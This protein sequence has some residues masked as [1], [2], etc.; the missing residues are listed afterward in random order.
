MRGALQK[1]LMSPPLTAL[2]SLTRSKVGL[3]S[4]KRRG[5]RSDGL[6]AKPTDTL[7]F[8][9]LFR[10]AWILMNSPKQVHL[11]EWLKRS[12]LFQLKMS[13]SQTSF[14]RLKKDEFR[15][16]RLLKLRATFPSG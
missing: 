14:E 9:L 8:R 15:A 1:V 13:V 2:C 6:P 12:P 11:S 10:R 3:T 5:G 7:S 4:C 16:V